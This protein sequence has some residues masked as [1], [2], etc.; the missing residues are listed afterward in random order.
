MDSPSSK[1]KRRPVKPRLVGEFNL[2]YLLE[3]FW[4][5]KRLLPAPILFTPILAVLLSYLIPPAYL[6]TTTIV[7]KN[8]EILNP[9]VRYETAVSLTDYDR[10]KRFEKMV[11][12]RPLIEEAIAEMGMFRE[13]MDPKE[14]EWM[15]EQVRSGIRLIGLTGDSFQIGYSASDPVQAK[16]MVETISN[17][18][19]ERSL[20]SSRRE[21]SVAVDFIREQLEYY[22]AA[23]DDAEDKLQAF[24]TENID[25]LQRLNTLSG[26]LREY[27]NKKLD[28]E[29]DLQQKEL[30]AKLVRERLDG[31]KPMVVAQA[32]FVQNTPYKKQYQELQMKLGELLSTRK[33]SHPEV[34]KVKRELEFID[35]LLKAE[36]EQRSASEQR[37][38]RSPVYEELTARLEDTQIEV[39]VLKDEIA[40]Y[41]KIIADLR[42]KLEKMPELQ[43]RLDQLQAQVR[44]NEEIYD[45]LRIKLEHAKV[46][47]EVEMQQQT[48]RFEIIDPPLVPLSRYQPIRKYFLAAGLAGGFMLSISL[49][50]L[51]EFLDPRVLRAG[52]LVR[53]FGYNILGD[54]PKVFRRP[55]GPTV[56]H[57]F[58]PARLVGLFEPLLRSKRLVLPGDFPENKILDRPA[59]RAA[60][61]PQ[62]SGERDPRDFINAFRELHVHLRSSFE[63]KDGLVCGVASATAGEGKTLITSNLA[64]LAAADLDKP[65]LVIDANMG[66]PELSRLMDRAEAPGFAEVMNGEQ[67]AMDCIVAG[68]RPGVF[69][70][71]AGTAQSPGA[72]FRTEEVERLY[73]SLRTHY[74]LILVEMPDLSTHPEGLS[75]GPATD[76]VVLV[77]GMYGVKKSSIGSTIGKLGEEHVLGFVLNN[78]EHWLPDWLYRF[79]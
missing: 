8:T 9:L 44:T 56:F 24:K 43:R 4:R 27:Q 30:T 45:T 16:E 53:K 23:L 14:L 55:Q 37:E 66:D 22:A 5:R 3:V 36:R 69:L 63:E 46:S 15:V 50:F 6:S 51:V 38:V 7:L 42:A 52:E 26:E 11:Y 70:L 19:I 47:R 31:E 58:L 12:S 28:A 73:A 60:E 20:E 32:L 72:V 13:G 64:A 41:T 65:V 48:N 39:R 54:V 75:V 25:S 62:R 35:K 10:L 61:T 76:G 17:L 33:E 71:P 40:E 2:K 34:I 1:R 18:F 67:D 29:M 79:V 74:S 21:A 77:V 78:R 49:V 57:R 68:H 59:L